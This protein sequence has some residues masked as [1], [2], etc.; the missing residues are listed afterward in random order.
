MRK[1]VSSFF[2]KFEVARATMKVVDVM[3]NA[4]LKANQNASL[5]LRR[6]VQP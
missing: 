6:P 3:L 5:N 2:S 4:L 1:L